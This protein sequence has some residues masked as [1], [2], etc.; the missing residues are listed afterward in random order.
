M[1]NYKY[2]VSKKITNSKIIILE[3]FLKKNFYEKIAEEISWLKTNKNCDKIFILKKK[4]IKK[5]YTNYNNFGKNQK[6]L[7][8]LLSSK[9]FKIFLKRNLNIKFSI[10]PEKSKMFSGFNVARK[11]SYLRPHADFNFNNKIKKFRTINL[12]LYFNINWKKNF[13]GNLTFYNYKTLKKKYEFTANANRAIIFLTNK[14]TIHGY[15][16]IKSN[17]HRISLNFYYYTNQNLSF[18]KKPHKTIWR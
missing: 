10:F 12:L 18:D 13:G 11:G 4:I 17:Q 3:N 6:K 16:K 5:E 2:I 7:I 9:K 8:S 1:L 15:S 14:Y